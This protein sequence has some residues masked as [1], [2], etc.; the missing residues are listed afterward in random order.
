MKVLFLCGVF[1]EENEP[2][3]IMKA[4]RPIEYSA[5]IM[6]K[7]L[8]HGLQSQNV[9]LQVL[10]APFVGSFPNASR[11]FNLNW[12][13]KEKHQYQ[14][15]N[16][17][18][19][20]GIRNFS[21][22]KALKK[23]II[24][25]AKSKEDKKVIYVYSPHTPFLETAVYAKKI[26]PTIK[27]CLIL[28]DLPQYMNL[29]AKVSTLYKWGKKI[30]VDKF[31]RLNQ[32]VDSF[33]LLTE[34]MKEKVDTRKKPCVVIEG[35]IEKQDLETQ[36]ESQS[37]KVKEEKLIVY[38]GK[39]NE[40]FGAKLLVDAFMK[41]KNPNYRLALCGKGDA[42]QYI[43]GKC[44]ED[45]R[46]LY[47]GQVS[48]LVAREWVQKA[49]VLVNPRQNNEEYTKYSFPSK[50]IE[51]LL[52]GNPVVGYMLYGMPNDYTKFMYIVEGNQDVD[53]ARTIE[54]ALYSEEEDRK[55]KYSSAC[56][57]LQKLTAEEVAKELLNIN[58]V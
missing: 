39:L 15:V 47:L 22:A 46:I 25:F 16:F 41:L 1:A 45:G 17:N 13:T 24:P 11:I 9:D 37:N 32:Q 8:I 50:N 3:I 23:A 5:N 31:E 10:S 29:N 19:I 12:E 27:I 55:E 43:Q 56:K 52:S 36:K 42:E 57:Y 7:K 49:D 20:W 48:A 53:L 51:Y 30:D 38:T 6:Q 28:P 14:Y 58:H 2:E 18:N 40:K 35:V 44:K 4:K 21:R 33:M 26:D 54:A 34:A